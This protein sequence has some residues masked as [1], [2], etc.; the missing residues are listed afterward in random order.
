VKSHPFL[1]IPER[2]L[3]LSLSLPFVFAPHIA[4]SKRQKITIGKQAAYKAKPQKHQQNILSSPQ[5]ANPRANQ[6]DSRA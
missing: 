6:G 4:I 2:D 5:T 1:V 3:L